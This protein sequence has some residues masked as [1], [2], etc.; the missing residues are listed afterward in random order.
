MP[1]P[2]SSPLAHPPRVSGDGDGDEGGTQPSA[3][4][5]GVSRPARRSGLNV[6]TKAEMAD[7][8][9]TAG[10]AGRPARS[11]AGGGV[12]GTL[13]ITML[14][15][16]A[17]RTATATTTTTAATA[18]CDG[19]PPAATL[20]R[21]NAAA[22]AT[23]PSTD[24]L[25]GGRCPFHGRVCARRGGLPVC[26]AEGG[27]GR[28]WRPKGVVNKVAALLLAAL[29]QAVKAERQRHYRSGASA[30]RQ[31]AKAPSRPLLPLRLISATPARHATVLTG[32]SQQPSLPSLPPPPTSTYL[33]LP[34]SATAAA[35]SVVRCIVPLR[36]RCPRCN[37]PLP[38][39]RGR[40]V[41]HCAPVSFV[42]LPPPPSAYF[43]L[44]TASCA[45]STHDT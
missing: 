35:V 30:H 36:R 24:K 26:T 40:H 12:S 21:T 7:R 31:P 39:S 29:R 28:A 43:A 16:L 8:K 33:H 25:R 11:A 38:W 27:H 20:S 22:D 14:A 18:D 3:A 44:T 9:R 1:A 15:P 34:S 10:T 45:P 2:R 5:P 13:A 32:P 17:T 19:L 42:A 41:R 6:N 4:L 23:W 37:D